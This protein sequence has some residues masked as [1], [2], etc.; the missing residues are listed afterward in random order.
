MFT[1]LEITC[2]VTQHHISQHL[3]VHNGAWTWDVIVK[4]NVLGDCSEIRTQGDMDSFKYGFS[5]K[6][7][8]ETVFKKIM[9]I[10]PLM[11]KGGCH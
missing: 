10:N 3:R 2:P 1:V 5:E 8:F 11:L 9:S 7:C 4:N 6:S